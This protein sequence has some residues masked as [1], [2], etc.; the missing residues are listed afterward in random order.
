MFLIWSCPSSG[1]LSVTDTFL[2][3]GNA[4][5]LKQNVVMTTKRKFGGCS[6]SRFNLVTYLASRGGDFIPDSPEGAPS[7]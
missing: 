1:F 2:F 6:S 3:D 7:H 4:K 5:V